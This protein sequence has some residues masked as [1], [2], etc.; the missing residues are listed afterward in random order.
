ML[1]RIYLLRN[2]ADEQLVTASLHSWRGISRSGDSLVPSVRMEPVVMLMTAVTATWVI[3]TSTGML[4]CSFL[5]HVI[6]HQG[7]ANGAPEA[8]PVVHFCRV[9]LSVC[10]TGRACQC[11]HDVFDK[12]VIPSSQKVYAIFCRDLLECF[13]SC[14]DVC[15]PYAVSYTA[16]LKDPTVLDANTRHMFFQAIS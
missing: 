2:T 4:A 15:C 3:S 13:N 10:C 6:G 14:V 12:V 5:H 8:S 1:T 11:Q 9:V 16:S 7:A